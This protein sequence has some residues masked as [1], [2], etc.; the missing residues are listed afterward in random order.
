MRSPAYCIQHS[1]AAVFCA[2][3]TNCNRANQYKHA[4]RKVIASISALIAVILTVS[5]RYNNKSTKLI[6]GDVFVGRTELARLLDKYSNRNAARNSQASYSEL[7]LIPASVEIST[8]KADAD[9]SVL[10]SDFNSNLR[11]LRA[12]GGLDL[13]KIQ[14][15]DGSSQVYMYSMQT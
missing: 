14:Q 8:P 3:Q 5:I 7:A 15:L 13:K 12:A 1:E 11:L 2:A 9:V 4:W 10:K 6:S